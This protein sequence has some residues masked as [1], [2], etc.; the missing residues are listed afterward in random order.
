[1]RR[2]HPPRVDGAQPG[3]P[4]L[5]PRWE[6]QTQGQVTEEKSNEYMY[7]QNIVK[8]NAKQEQEQDQ[9]HRPEGPPHRTGQQQEQEQGPT[10]Q[11][12][13]SEQQQ[14]QEQ[15]QEQETHRLSAY[16]RVWSAGHRLSACIRVPEVCHRLSAYIRMAWMALW[17]LQWRGLLCLQAFRLRRARGRRTGQR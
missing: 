8:D 7:K 9:E 13:R 11:P 2:D 15:E 17:R 4:C 10:G 16:I 5:P 3:G 1:M 14:E 12:Q 6:E